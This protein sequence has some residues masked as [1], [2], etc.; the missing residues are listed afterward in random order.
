MSKSLFK[1]IGTFVF[2]S[3]VWSAFLFIIAFILVNIKGYILKDALLIE[4]IIFV[5][6][7][8]FASISGNP[9]GLSIKAMGQSN[10]QYSSNANLEITRMESEKTKNYIEITVKNG[11]GG[12]S[13]LFSGIVCMIISFLL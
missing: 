8:G 9:K 12:I 11:T 7:G 13:L 2:L 6:L 5:V 4:S 3:I 1:S 10:S